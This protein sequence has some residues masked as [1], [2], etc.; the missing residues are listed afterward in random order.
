MTAALPKTQVQFLN[1]R[2]EKLIGTLLD[3]EHV[4]EHTA[5]DPLTAAEAGSAAAPVVILAHGY[6]SSQNSELLVRLAT[7]LARNCHLASLRCVQ[8]PTA[9][10]W[11]STAGLQQ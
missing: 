2:S 1:H 6:M 7:A 8:A 5:D 10:A 9:A 11:Q 3:P 4:T